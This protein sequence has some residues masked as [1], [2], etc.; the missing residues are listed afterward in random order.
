MDKSLDNAL[1]KFDLIFTNPPFG[2]KVKV[3]L[4]IS[5]KYALGMNWKKEEDG[6]FT[7]SESSSSEAPEVLLSSSAKSS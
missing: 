6:T 5:R 2:A 4:A 3:D 1:G 7:S